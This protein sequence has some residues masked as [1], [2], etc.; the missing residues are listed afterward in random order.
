[1]FTVPSTCPR[2]RSSAT[3]RALQTT[4]I[5]GLIFNQVEVSRQSPVEFSTNRLLTHCGMR[6]MTNRQSFQLLSLLSLGMLWGWVVCEYSLTS[7]TPFIIFT[8]GIKRCW[9]GPTGVLARK[10]GHYSIHMLPVF[11]T[12]WQSF[13]GDI[14]GDSTCEEMHSSLFAFSPIPSLKTEKLKTTIG[15]ALDVFVSYG[16]LLP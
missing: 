10:I 5:L 6:S 16:N 2:P 15:T 7:S 13:P 12:L 1:M 9:T 11:V 4:K 14:V 8:D 3:H